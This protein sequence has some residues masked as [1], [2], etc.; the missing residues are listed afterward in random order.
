MAR[1]SSPQRTPCP[2]AREST[3]RGARPRSQA[4][5]APWSSALPGQNSAK[6]EAMNRTRAVGAQCLQMDW[7]AIADV[8][9]EVISLILFVLLPHVAIPLGLGQDRGGGHRKGN[10]VSVDQSHLGNR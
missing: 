1:A 3:E 10:C 5:F 9:V 8:S 2:C 4:S 7:R 6:A